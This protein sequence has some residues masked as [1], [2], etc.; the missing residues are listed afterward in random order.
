M[1]NKSA[2]RA[3]N[4][5]Y[6]WKG[7][8]K[9][10]CQLVD[11]DSYFY[12]LDS[13]LGWNKIYGLRG[14]VQYQCVVPLEN[15]EQGLNEHK[16]TNAGSGSFLAVLKRFG[17][18]QSNFSFPMEGYTLAPDFPVNNK[19]LSLMNN[20]DKITLKHGGR[21]Y[22]AKD[23]RISR[24]ILLKLIIVQTIYNMKKARG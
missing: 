24:E 20:L 8:R 9:P 11:L 1:V 14:F 10:R 21:F 7:K 12:P 13:I 4:E 22:L 3:F 23:S 16:L 19:N 17:P 2:V 6:Y 15:A 18:Q 5:L